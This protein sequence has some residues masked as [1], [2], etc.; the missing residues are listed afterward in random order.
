MI[1]EAEFLCF[2]VTQ[3]QVLSFPSHR[4]LSFFHIRR[5]KKEPSSIGG[6]GV[7][8]SSVTQMEETEEFSDF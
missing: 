7:N 3:P 4:D 6:G 5:I 2:K 8:P 1:R